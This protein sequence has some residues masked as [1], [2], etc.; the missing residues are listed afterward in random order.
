[1]QLQGRAGNASS[2]NGQ[3]QP[4][5]CQ[6]AACPKSTTQPGRTNTRTSSIMW[7]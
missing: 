2:S 6:A 4:G 1:L 7:L 5:R 3:P